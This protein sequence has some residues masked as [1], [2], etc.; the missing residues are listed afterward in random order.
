MTYVFLWSEIKVFVE[1]FCP[2]CKKLLGY[3]EGDMHLKT[4]FKHDCKMKNILKRQKFNLKN[5]I[6]APGM[7][8][9]EHLRRG[10]HLK[11]EL[12]LKRLQ[13]NIQA[14]IDVR[15][16]LRLL[17]EYG[18]QNVKN[19]IFIDRFTAICLTHPATEPLKFLYQIKT[20]PTIMSPYSPYGIMR[21]VTAEEPEEELEKLLFLG[22]SQVKS[23]EK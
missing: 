10:F 1:A 16:F 3:D 22:G 7:V 2:V 23:Y 8:S 11:R 18:V 4:I 21:G 9:F 5:P 19:A 12:H 13:P 15:R 20:V 14:D 6:F 17:R